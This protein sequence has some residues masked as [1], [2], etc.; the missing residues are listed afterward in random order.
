MGLD[1][2]NEKLKVTSS[3][4]SLF[5]LNNGQLLSGKISKL[6]VF[7]DKLCNLSLK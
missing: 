3:Q 7:E 1:R 2:F 5:I 4:I 6:K